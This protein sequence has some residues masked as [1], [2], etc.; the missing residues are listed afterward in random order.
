MMDNGFKQSI[1]IFWAII[2]I[3]SMMVVATPFFFTENYILSI[4]PNCYSRAF[5]NQDCS[6]CGVTR[7]FIQVSKGNFESAILHNQMS[8][9]IF[10]LFS[11]NSILFLAF[12]TYIFRIKNIVK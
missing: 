11:M 7:G 12:L 8:P 4:S 3:I 10:L 9:Y 1:I 2:S 5:L 6:L